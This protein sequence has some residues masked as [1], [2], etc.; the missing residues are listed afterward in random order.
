MKT[1]NKHWIRK[2][3][4]YLC[5]SCVIAVGLIS[6]I[7]SVPESQYVRDDPPGLYGLKGW[8]Y[9]VCWDE[10]STDIDGKVG[11]PL[12]V[13]GPRARC[14]PSS[15]DFTARTEIISGTLPPGLT[16]T[17]SN[18]HIE[19]IPTKRGHWIVK[20]KLYNVKCGDTYYKG[21]EQELRF[22]ITGSGRVTQ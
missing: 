1:R 20:I 10:C 14:K 22:H 8:N 17:M 19:G 2:F 7:G 5:L 15:S 21:F 12:H 6:I 11:H 13:E 18:F 9:T 4:L 16:M 3:W